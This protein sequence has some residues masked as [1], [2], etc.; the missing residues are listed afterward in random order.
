MTRFLSVFFMSLAA[1]VSSAYAAPICNSPEECKAV[2]AQA[3]AL[4]LIL[5]P[6]PLQRV[7]IIGVVFTRNT[8]IPALGEAYKDPWGTVW[9][10]VAKSYKTRDE[11]VSYCRSIGAFLP[12]S[13]QYERL[14]KYLGYGTVRGYSVKVANGQ[15]DVLPDLSKTL[16]WTS[17]I[18]P[19]DDEGIAYGFNN[20]WGFGADYVILPKSKLFAVRCVFRQEYIT[21]PIDPYDP[22]YPEI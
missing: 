17:T 14:T 11:A 1:A 9:G 13:N 10:S 7:S 21:P 8:S 3:N 2:I 5:E 19:P 4:L 12:T 16:F 18:Y 6:A 15:T 22:P 20:S